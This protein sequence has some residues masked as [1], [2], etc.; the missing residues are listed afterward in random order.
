MIELFRNNTSHVVTRKKNVRIFRCILIKETNE[1]RH[2]RNIQRALCEI[3][4]IDTAQKD[5]TCSSIRAY[6]T[7]KCR[8]IEYRLIFFS[9][10]EKMNRNKNDAYLQ[11]LT[12]RHDSTETKIETDS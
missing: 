3:Q 10:N 2:M 12:H 8:S 5:G 9:K 11:F 1:L 4:V 6:Q 7:I